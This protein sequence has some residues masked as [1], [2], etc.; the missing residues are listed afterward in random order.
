MF[1]VGYMRGTKEWLTDIFD[2]PSKVRKILKGKTYEIENPCISILSA[3]TVDWLNTKLRDHDILSGFLARF[4]YVVPTV[5]RSK[6]LPIPPRAKPAEQQA[7]IRQLQDIARVEGCATLAPQAEDLY[8]QWYNDQHNGS[9]SDFSDECMAP[10]ASRLEAYM[11]KLALIL[12]VCEDR[13]LEIQLH[14]M[15]IAYHLVEML[16]ANIRNLLETELVFT[17][18][19]RDVQRVR[20]IIRAF[21][22]IA[23]SDLLRKFKNGRNRLNEAIGNL[24]Q[25][26]ELRVDSKARPIRYWLRSSPNSTGCAT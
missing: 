25:Q 4:L 23:R 21:P 10:F 5:E 8:V 13:T 15:S 19:A 9:N 18:E 11:L 20:K 17:E 26:N 16:S 12:Q 1:N 22:G 14:N 24:E 6:T 2:C 7:L 3:S